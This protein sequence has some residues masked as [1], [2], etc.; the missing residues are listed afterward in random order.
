MFPFEYFSN[1]TVKSDREPSMLAARRAKHGPLRDPNRM[2]LLTMDQFAHM[3][4]KI[5]FLDVFSVTFGLFK[6]S[7]SRDDDTVKGLNL[8][9]YQINTITVH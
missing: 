7:R 3:I 6:G 1:N 5:S 4:L 9:L 8:L 2:F